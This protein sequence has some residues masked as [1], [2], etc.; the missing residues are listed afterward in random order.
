[1][2]LLDRYLGMIFLKAFANSLVVFLVLYVIVDLFDRLS[3]FLDVSGLVV[4][5]YYFYRLPWIGYQVMPVAVL[6]AALLSLGNLA[7]HNELLAMK[8]GQLSFVRIV[9]PILILSFLTSV[10]AL[11]LGESIIPR[12]NERAL[13]VYRVKVKKVSAFRRTR[14]NDI[15]YRA[16]GNRFLNISLMET[17][18]GTVQGFTLFE[19]SPDFQLVRRV[20]A[21]EA[22]WQDGKWMLK[23]GFVSLT[24][25]DG[26]YQVNPFTSLALDL[27]EKPEDLAQVVRES[28]EMNSAELRE[29]I[30]KLIKSGVNSI[31]YQVDLA[32]K[33]STAFVSL[34][35]ALIGIAFALRT[36]KGGV[37]AWTGACVV[38]AVCYWL[39]LLASINLGRGGVLPPLVAAW[40]P[41][42]LFV[43]AGLG[44]VLTA[45][46]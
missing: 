45:K 9:A 44:S 20:D 27:E 23:D 29:Y 40:L 38:V 22:R 12:M 39:L 25:P 5:Q 26:T 21:R 6:L 41:N 30:G 13:N 36:G 18:S 19:L 14:E 37:M 34:V 3:R 46:G 16:K 35:M 42:A 32:A 33:T 7:R 17:A 43:A 28:E 15:W 2:R 31:R 24:R 10:A 4:I 11:I 1:M 8:I